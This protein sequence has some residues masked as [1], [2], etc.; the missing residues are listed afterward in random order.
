MRNKTI[1]TT[2]NLMSQRFVFDY[3]KPEN[4][5]CNV[6]GYSQCILFNN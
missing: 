3:K 5:E 4:T 6:R 1:H 2:P